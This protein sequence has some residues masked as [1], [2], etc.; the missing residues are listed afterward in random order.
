MLYCSYDLFTSLSRVWNFTT[1]DAYISWVYARHWVDGEG[2]IWH[3][4]LPIVEGFS[5]FLWTAIAALVLLLKLPL[6]NTM[7]VI[8]IG[9]LMAGLMALYRLARLFFSPLL[10]ILPVFIFSHYIGSVWWTLK[11]LETPLY[12][13]LSIVLAWQ[14]LKAWGYAEENQ[15]KEWSTLAWFFTNIS[16]LALSLTRFEG[17]IW[18]IPILFFAGCQFKHRQFP[19]Q[20]MV[21]SW[22]FISL[23]CFILPYTAY[24]IWRIAYFGHWIPN[25]YQCK[26]MAQGQFFLVDWDYFEVLLPFLVASLPYLIVSRDC[27]QLLLWLPSLLYA[28][29]LWKANPVISHFIRLFLAPFAL[30]S[31]LPVLGV[32]E[33][34][35]YFRLKIDSKLLTS[36]VIFLITVL[37]SQGNEPNYLEKS[38]HHYQERTQNRLDVA[39]LLNQKAKKGASV[40][41]G[42]CGLI[43]YM[44]RKDLRFVDSQC[45]NNAEITQEPYKDH[46]D[47]YAKHLK[48]EIKPDWLIINFYPLEQHGDS[49]DVLLKKEDFFEDYQLVRTLKSGFNSDDSGEKIIDYV[50]KVY[51]RK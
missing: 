31:L 37:F 6:V 34:S 25:S 22:G 13:T 7:K 47:L 8:A 24:F 15:R 38:V 26:A 23:L 45:L 50:Y 30:F 33:F 11:G 5:N 39:S 18:I 19:K 9:C 16:L 10:A 49:L 21:Y 48:R 28:L 36:L 46:L 32:L 51:R 41:L 44:A 27:R 35:S 14:V 17:L 12:V 20:S 42:D 43:P 40:L 2:L 3:P 29:L 1:D 4:Q